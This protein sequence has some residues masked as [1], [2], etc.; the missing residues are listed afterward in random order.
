MKVV[1]INI[2]HEDKIIILEIPDPENHFNLNK[3]LEEIEMSNNVEIED[4]HHGENKK[5]WELIFNLSH[6]VEIIE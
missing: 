3:A 1:K 4:D 5:F 6:N 2:K